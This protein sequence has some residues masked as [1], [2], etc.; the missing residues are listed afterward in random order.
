LPKAPACIASTVDIPVT[1]AAGDREREDLPASY[2]EK[3]P[4][5]APRST[6]YPADSTTT[7]A[8]D[9]Q[10]GHDRPQR[11]HHRLVDT[12]DVMERVSLR[13]THA[14]T[15]GRRRERQRAHHHNAGKQSSHTLQKS[16]T[17]TSS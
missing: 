11:H 2:R 14:L 8:G 16:P 15:G 3:S 7:P 1:A 10:L 9:S 5:L 12:T 4:D 13:T 6:G 17:S